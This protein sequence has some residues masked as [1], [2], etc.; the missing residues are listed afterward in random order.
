MCYDF[1][2]SAISQSSPVFYT[3]ALPQKRGFPLSSISLAKAADG[4]GQSDGSAQVN[5]FPQVL[6]SVGTAADTQ[7]EKPCI[8]RNQLPSVRPLL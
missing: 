1:S 3:C 4:A 2:S 7:P 5:L 8:Q 6:L